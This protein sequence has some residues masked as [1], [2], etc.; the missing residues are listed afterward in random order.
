MRSTL[1]SGFFLSPSL[2]MA[3]MA[4]SVA[5]ANEA[6]QNAPSAENADEQAG[7]ISDIVVTA[8]RTTSTVQRT[9]IAVT[10]ADATVLEERQIND[11]KNMGSIVPGLVVQPASSSSNAARIVLR[12]VGQESG[13]ILYDPGVGVYIDGV[14]QPRINGGFFDFFDIERLEVLRGPQGTLYGRNSSGGAIKIITRNPSLDEAKANGD[15]AYGTRNLFEARAFASVPLVANELGLSASVVKRNRDGLITSTKTGE[16]L[17]KVDSMAARAKLYYAPNDRFELAM[18]LDYLQDRGDGGIGVPITSYPGV[19]NPNA[20]VDRNL[21]TTELDGPQEAYVDSIGASANLRYQLSDSLTFSSITG[22]RW[23]HFRTA[24]DFAQLAAGYDLGGDYKASNYNFSQELNLEFKSGP[25]TAVTGLYYFDEHGTQVR[26]YL[27]VPRGYSTPHTLR[28]ETK[29]YA[30]FTEVNVNVLKDVSVIGGIRWT[31][32]DAYLSQIYPTTFNELQEAEASFSDVTPKVGINW[33]VGAQT[34]LYASY[35]AG[36]K[37]GG[38]NNI[39]PTINTATGLRRTPEVYNPETVDSYEAGFKFTS[40]DRKLRLNA[41]FFQAE[42]DGLQLPALIPGSA[43]ST[44]RNAT[45]ATIRG[46]E[47]EPTWRPIEGLEFFGAIAFTSGE[48]TG[49]YSCANAAGVFVD[50]SKNGIKGVIPEQATLGFNYETSLGNSGSLRFGGDW[51]YTSFYYNN[52]SNETRL[53]Q[54]EAAGI[55]N[56][57]IKWT[58]PSEALTVALEARNIANKKYYRNAL[59]LSNATSPA[60]TIYP[61]DPR[62]V[63]VRV[64]FKF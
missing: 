19:N 62:M 64:G 53:A 38:F 21:F 2:A 23:L 54:S 22:Y 63:N 29:A 26:G 3:L 4:P 1:R 57:F 50:C 7:G 28:R 52:V 10:A 41:A 51:Q 49:A 25:I 15:I 59:L 60:T 43:I 61:S 5:A 39:T 27:N 6:P 13:G 11:V 20:R 45:S 44:T 55:F 40:A 16:K 17:G 32:E 58:S 14:Y 42:Y 24:S 47:L 56:G 37:S 36:F 9:P 12:G 48:Y 31:K 34:M 18:G 33:Q 46:V 8:Q 30:A 35:T